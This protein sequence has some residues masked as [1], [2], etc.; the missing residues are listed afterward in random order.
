MKKTKNELTNTKTFTINVPTTLKSK[1]KEAYESRNIERISGQVK[2]YES[3]KGELAQKKI[4]FDTILKEFEID[5]DI[6]G[7]LG[8]EYSKAVFQ[9]LSDGRI[10]TL[11]NIIE[12][13]QATKQ[14][15][16][17]VLVNIQSLKGCKLFGN[18]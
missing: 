12:S 11:L 18:D 7:L 4:E 9:K 15:L 16:E 1:L 6:D 17:S 10:Q 8:E 3:L 2:V 13:Y 14:K 5:P